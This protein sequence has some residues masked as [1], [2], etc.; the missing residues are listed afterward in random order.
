MAT[1]DGVGDAAI[2]LGPGVW[3]VPTTPLDLVNSFVFR[4][5]DGQVTLVDTGLRNAPA[6]IL[7]ALAQIGTAPTEVTRIVVTHAHIDHAGGLADLAR[8][9]GAP[10]AAHEA[11]AD[12]LRA[13]RPPPLDRSTGVGKVLRRQT[14]F[15]PTAVAEEL[16]D[17]QV[18]D[19]GG[20]LR[21]VHTPGHTPGHVSLLHEGT[22]LLITGDAIWNIRTRVTWPVL[23]FCTDVALTKQ[24]A[25][26]LGELDYDVAAFTHGPEIR[27]R[28]R[29]TVRGFLARP[30][31][32]RGGF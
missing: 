6:R 18:L 25:H 27:D 23:S 9:T 20:G 10:V 32:F 13:G 15:A 22:R 29:E 31:G 3:R 14:G 16:V 12:H 8:R 26:V 7:A 30:R 19:V 2:A 11:D 24:T 4:D 5:A 1:L 21:V 28:A 17:G